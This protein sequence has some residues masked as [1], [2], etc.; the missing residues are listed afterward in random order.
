MDYELRRPYLEE[1]ERIRVIHKTNYPDYRVSYLSVLSSNV[2]EL[3]LKEEWLNFVFC[4]SLT[5]L[6]VL[7]LIYLNKSSILLS[8]H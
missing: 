8:L 7:T 5:L 3:R 2:H 6:G 4:Y 1:A